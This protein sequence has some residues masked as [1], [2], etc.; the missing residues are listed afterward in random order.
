MGNIG[1]ICLCDNRNYAARNRK[2]CVE[3]ILRSLDGIYARKQR[4]AHNSL[5]FRRFHILRYLDH[6]RAIHIVVAANGHNA[7]DELGISHK[8]KSQSYDCPEIINKRK[9]LFDFLDICIAVMASY[10]NYW[11]NAA[12]RIVG[13]IAYNF[14][15]IACRTYFH[16]S[17]AE[18]SE[19]VVVLPF[20]VQTRSHAD[21][22]RELNTKQLSL[23]RLPAVNE[24]PASQIVCKGHIAQKPQNPESYGVIF[25]DRTH[26][27]LFFTA[28]PH[29]EECKQ[30]IDYQ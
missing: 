21:R 7:V 3:M 5:N 17:G 25:F 20:S 1:H 9:I 8:R 22:V 16:E 4:I 11:D 18:E 29:S 27:K 2:N 24:H 6:H 30:A 28:E 14:D 13:K 15:R 23:K 26:F 12:R 10:Y 19:I